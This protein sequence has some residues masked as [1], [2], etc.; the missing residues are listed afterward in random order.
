MQPWTV[1]RGTLWALETALDPLPAC[2]ARV[3][4]EFRELGMADGASLAA[5][6]GLATPEPVAQRMRGRRRCFGLWAA[7]RL[8][9]YGW[10]THGPEC[11]GELE[12][13]F[14]LHDDE[15]YIWDCA[16][17]PA[18]RGQRCYSALLCH[19]VRQLDREG[20]P[21]IW[22]GAS[23]DNRPSTRG[24]ANAGFRPVVDLTYRRLYRLKL[25]WFRERA[26]RRRLLVA[27]AYRILLVEGERRFGP[28]AAGFHRA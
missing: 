18:M 14:N 16:T 28:L 11:V 10:V 3:E 17:D 27:A 25:L 2:A 5:A 22:I 13:R 12:R 8:A 9:S 4:V 7:G 15:A 19:I 26:Q 24:F 21:R 1:E 6:M 20:V 23:L